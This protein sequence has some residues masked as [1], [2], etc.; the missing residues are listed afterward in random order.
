MRFEES[1]A[2]NKGST[3]ILKE[4]EDGDG[5]GEDNSAT[6]PENN[7]FALIKGRLYISVCPLAMLYR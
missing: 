5:D 3:F 1:N 7:P 2:I 6:E 4:G